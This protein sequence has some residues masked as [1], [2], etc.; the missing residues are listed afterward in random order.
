MGVAKSTSMIYLEANY[1]DKNLAMVNSSRDMPSAI[2]EIPWCPYPVTIKKL[3]RIR[4][5]E[6]PIKKMEL[7]FR[8]FT[9]TLKN[10]ID[11]FWAQDSTIDKNE[12]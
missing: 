2:Y 6:S 5:V 1:S 12:L 11:E 3:R 8:L 4:D 9:E 7:T 10:E